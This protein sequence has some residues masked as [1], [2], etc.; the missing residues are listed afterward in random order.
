MG[1]FFFYHQKHRLFAA[2]ALAVSVLIGFLHLYDLGSHPDSVF[3][4]VVHPNPERLAPGSA[5]LVRIVVPRETIRYRLREKTS[6]GIV[7]FSDGVEKEVIIQVLRVP[8]PTGS[9]DTD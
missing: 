2:A 9:E 6:R 8:A 3:M 5:E 7:S 1:A 4:P